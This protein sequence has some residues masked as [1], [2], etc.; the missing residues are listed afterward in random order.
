MRF[1]AR[2]LFILALAFAGWAAFLGLREGVATDLFSLVGEAGFEGSPLARL[3]E[4]SADSVRVLCADATRAEALRARYPFD[5]PLD[6]TTFLETI[7]THGRGLLTPKSRELL[8]AGEFDRIRRS[9][10]RRDYS[11]VGL[12]SKSDDPYYFLNDFV[13]SLKALEPKGLPEGAVILTGRG[14]AIDAAVPGGGL[15][16][17]IRAAEADVGIWLSGTPF[18]TALA[19]RQT[20]REINV[21]GFL[22]LAAVLLFGWLLFRSFRFVLPMTLFLT[23][24]FLAA[25]GAVCLLPDRPHALTF[26]FGTTLIGLGVDYCFHAFSAERLEADFRK[27]LTGALV[28]SCLAFAPLLFS[29]VCVLRQM[30]VF[31]IVGMATIYAGVLLFEGP[32]SLQTEKR[33]EWLGSGFFMTL[34]PRWYVRL[35]LILAALFLGMCFVR[36]PVSS[37]PSLLHRPASVMARGEAKFAELSGSAA[38]MRLV[39]LTMWQRENDALKQKLGTDPARELGTVP[40]TTGTVPSGTFL[41][42]ADFPAGMAFRWQDADYLVLPEEAAKVIVGDFGET[43]SLKETLEGF[44]RHFLREALWMFVCAMILLCLVSLLLKRGLGI[45]LRPLAACV[46]TFLTIGLVAGPLTFFHILCFFI[47]F[48][49]GIDYSI[50]HARSRGDSPQNVAG[51][52]G[53]D[54]ETMGTV[55]GA[56]PEM[57]GDSPQRFDSKISKHAGNSVVLFSFLTSLIGFG[58]LAFTSFPVTRG[59]GLT[60]AVGLFWAYVLSLPVRT[61]GKDG[62]QTTAWHDQKEQ[63]AGRFRIRLMWYFYRFFGKNVAKILFLPGFLF[64]YPFCRPARAALR[65]YYAILGVKDRSFRH[66]LGFAWSMLDKTDACTLCKNPPKFTLTGDTGWQEGG[67]FLLSTH[68]GCIEVLPALRPPRGQSPRV[69]AFQ[70]LGHDAEF[71]R[72]FVEKMDANRLTLHAVEDIGVETAVEMKAAIAR[73]EIVLMAGDRL[74]AA[75]ATGKRSKAFEW[76]FWGRVCR[77][78]KGVFRFAAMMESPIYAIICV[79]TGWNAYEVKARRLGTDPLVEYVAFLAENV[80]RY[81]YQWYQFY[82]FFENSASNSH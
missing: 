27:K 21:L 81:P 52:M 44:F 15:L 48:G 70:Q 77:W 36:P 64:I 56:Q 2:G 23:A 69:H 82:D 8:A 45:V 80:R 41:T 22:S 30:S 1:L 20:I 68:L 79:K 25:T 7:R 19:R 73:G 62:T 66:L 51:C 43:I 75:A 39:N 71:T 63:S 6:P 54:P 18:H 31:S 37:D 60:L 76:E 46:F 29:S 40:K 28:T 38:Q 10:K 47:I 26:L 33:A 57:R 13:V 9:V 35:F 61:R 5:A 55:P 4:V 3:N 65:S 67:C 17:L 24:G 58:L 14:S 34:P 53:T 78:P 11:G 72:F 12:F 32:V 50:F 16:A 49:L 42:A 74:S 59:M